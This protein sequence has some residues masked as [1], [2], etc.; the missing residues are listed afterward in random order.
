MNPPLARCNPV[1]TL[2]VMSA[3]VAAIPNVAPVA[4]TA[5]EAIFNAQFQFSPPRMISNSFGG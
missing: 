1:F 5:S 2:P 3:A 4:N